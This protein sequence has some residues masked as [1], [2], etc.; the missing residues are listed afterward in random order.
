MRYLMTTT[1]SCVSMWMS[2]ARRWI[3]SKRIEST[4]LMI[5]L[6]SA[7]IRSIERTS[8]PSS[9]SRTSWIR[10]SS[11]ASSSTRCVDSDFWRMSWSAAREPTFTFRRAFRRDSSS[12]RFTTSEGS[13]ITTESVPLSRSSGTNSNLSIHSSGIDR[14]TSASIRNVQ[15][16][17]YGRPRRSASCRARVSSEA[18]S[19]K[20]GIAVS[21]ESARALLIVSP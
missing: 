8:S 6:A 20:R 18:A 10:N 2:D 9:S 14:K 11:V 7:V 13:A 3:A 15:R 16:S 1:W 5:G 21:D 12:S 19:R 4:S 17:T